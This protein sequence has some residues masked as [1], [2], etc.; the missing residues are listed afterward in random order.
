MMKSGD[1]LSV[2]TP[3]RCTSAGSL[4]TTCATRFCTCTCA[5]SRSV[6]TANVTVSVIRPSEVDC[7]N[8]YSMSSTPLSC[9]SSGPATVSAMTLG[10]APGYDSRTTTVGGATFG[11]SVTG[12]WLSAIAP[13]MTITSES[14]TAKIGRVM[15]NCAMFMAA[16]PCLLSRDR[17]AH[18]AEYAEDRRR[19][20]RRTPA[21]RSARR[22]TYRRQ[23]LGPRRATR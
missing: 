12:N 4:G 23:G 3:V 6:P 22:A 15:K 1:D 16:R 8:V 9:C 7:E 20:R 10:L 17:S 19:R 14:T 13:P 18:Q 2:V 21:V 11:Y 5:L